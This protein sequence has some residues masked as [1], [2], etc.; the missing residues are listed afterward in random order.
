MENEDLRDKLALLTDK[1]GAVVE[2]LPYLDHRELEKSIA[3]ADLPE[4]LTQLKDMI[5]T[6]VFSLRKDIRWL[7]R[8]I[9]NYDE[10]IS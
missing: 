5:L 8:R 7:Q 9:Q 6:H 2:Y 4:K 10:K 1:S 3:G